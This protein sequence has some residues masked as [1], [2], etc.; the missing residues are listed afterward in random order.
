M[1]QPQRGC[2]AGGFGDGGGGATSQ[3]TQARLEAGKGK[4]RGAPR[5]LDSS[6]TGLMLHSDLQ[7]RGSERALSKPPSC[8]TLLQQRRDS[9]YTNPLQ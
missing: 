1:R 8:G 2:H 7:E 5:S 6:P 9:G 4:E 3:G